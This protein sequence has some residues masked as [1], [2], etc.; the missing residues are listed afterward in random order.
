MVDLKEPMRRE[1]S[2]EESVEVSQ[3]FLTLL[4]YFLSFY[5]S[6]HNVII[7][8]L[9]NIFRGNDLLLDVHFWFLFSL[10][11]IYWIKKRLPIPRSYL[12]FLLSGS[13]SRIVIYT[14][15]MYVKSW[16]VASVY[17]TEFSL[18]ISCVF[19]YQKSYKDRFIFSGFAGL[20]VPYYLS[21]VEFH[22]VARK[23]IFPVV[24][25]E[26]NLSKE[27]CAGSKVDITFPHQK[28]VSSFLSI[29]ECGFKNNNAVIDGS[30][31]IFNEQEHLIHLRIF[32]LTHK[33]GKLFWK[34]VRLVKVEP[35]HELVL[36]DYLNK[37]SI[38]LL[39]APERRNLG[40]LILIPKESKLAGKITFTPDMIEKEIL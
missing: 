13:L 2:T 5:L 9:L 3:S 12:F 36:N 14:T 11:L 29:G 1:Y 26:I 32:K 27:G 7:P 15:V 6:L 25:K 35:R 22:S 37:D 8:L 28:P 33:E 31:R 40:I 30:F 34:F 24:T 10:P 38:F 23:V 4:F 19:A 16:T 17:L 18:I 20:L 39:K 21:Q